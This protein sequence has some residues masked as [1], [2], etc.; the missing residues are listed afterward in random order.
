M[1]TAPV[2]LD[3]ADRMAALHALA[4]LDTAP[5]QRF[6]RI[7]R[8]AAEWFDVPISLVSLVDSERT[9]FKS[10]VGLDSTE[11][12][13]STSFCGHAIA[14]DGV[15]VVADA[16][17]DPRFADNPV[18]TGEPHVRFY[19]GAPVHSD[20]Q[21]VGTLCLVDHRPREFD[22]RDQS[23]L[24]HLAGLVEQ[25]FAEHESDL[26]LRRLSEAERTLRLL[27]E[28]IS[29]AFIAMDHTG[30]IV[31][32]N[33]S[34]ELLFRSDRETLVGRPVTDLVVDPEPD[35]VADL[36]E[37]AARGERIERLEAVAR[38]DDGF[39]HDLD[40]AFG[41][42]Q[43]LGQRV[44]TASARD[45]T[46]ERAASR[47]F[48]LLRHRHE[49][50]LTSTVDAIVLLDLDGR[51]EY[52]NPAAHDLFGIADGKLVGRDL[53]AT[54]HHTRIDGS[55]YPW[56]DCP[57]FGTLRHGTAVQ[58]RRERYW[59]SDG[60]AVDVTMTAAPVHDGERVIGSVA[61]L[62]D[63]T[64]QVQLER[65]K[66]E[67]IAV[68]SHELRTP[69]TALRGALGL[70]HGGVFGDLATDAAEMIAVAVDSAD[71]LI[72]LVNDILDLQR[73][74]AGRVELDLAPHVLDDLVHAAVRTVRPLAAE[75]AIRIDVTV[76][77]HVEL[78]CDIDRTT[79]ILTNLVANAIKF[80]PAG[81]TVSVQAIPDATSVVITVRDTGRGIPADRLEQ[82]FDRFVQVEVGDARHGSGT[83]LGLPIA[84]ALAIQHGGTLTVDS[85]PGLGSTFTL[86]LPRDPAQPIRS[87]E[88][89]A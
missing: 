45:L 48:E 73:L 58:A 59:R 16:E 37:R 86:T 10:C 41:A 26:A 62:T 70:V 82:I 13:R 5:E 88:V 17:A 46:A 76:P 33:G 50:I 44:F 64:A 25:Q 34:A 60:S 63:A 39:L 19:A 87:R 42:A 11:S 15:F 78:V 8:L 66:D 72:R 38:D 14:A 65:A 3:E 71:R 30:R 52:A 35:A 36:L 53:H 83:G 12:E 9:W 57:M 29:D 27:A 21:R 79:Q 49:V 6:D 75:A 74:D 28:S 55:H 7:T 54:A 23:I 40:V 56:D 81:S 32:A 20:G 61:V 2:L 22:A 80:S 89:Q 77:D 68:V 18:V 51:V 4:I 69:L 84:R 24:V 31:Y 1:L 67:F 47:R 43:F 85:E